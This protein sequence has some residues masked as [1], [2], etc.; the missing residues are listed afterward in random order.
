M[1]TLVAK[2]IRL[3]LPAFAG[4]LALVV[5]PMWAMCFLPPDIRSS[6]SGQDVMV[7][8][9]Y[10]IGILMLALSSFGREF[11]LKTLPFLLAQPVE[12]ARIWR[13]KVAVLAVF[14]SVAVAL[15]C[16]LAD[17]ILILGTKT[18]AGLPLFVIL[19]IAFTAGAICL[20]LLLRQVAAA[21]WLALLIPMALMLGLEALRI[22]DSFLFAILGLYAVAAFLLARWQFLHLQDTA[23]TGGVVAF[24]RQRQATEQSS[25]RCHRPWAALFWKEIQMQ[26]VTFFGMACLLALHLGVV[27]IRKAG[28]HSFA[29]TT[30]W[31]LEAFGMMWFVVPILAGSQSVAEE[32]KLGT[33]QAHLC[34]PISR[35]AQWDL[36]LLVV[37]AISMVSAALFFAVQHW[38]Q[39]LSFVEM[40]LYFLL[41]ALAGF[42]GSTLTSGVVQALAVGSL[43]LLGLW[44]GL[45]GGMTSSP[46]W[47]G[48]LLLYIGVPLLA[49]T[50]VWL[51]YR[52]FG[53]V[54][55]SWPL[56]RRNILALLG[57][58]AF[59]F[60]L[61]AAIY[62]RAWEYLT[63]LESTPGPARLS[64]QHPPVF[65]TGGGTAMAAILPDG[66]LW[67]DR[68]GL[69]RRYR[70]TDL[71]AK[72]VSVGGNAFVPGSNWA[73][74]AVDSR[75][76]VAIR[77]DGTLW[78][79]PKQRAFWVAARSTFTVKAAPWVQFGT[80]TDWQSVV[81]G[82][83]WVRDPEWTMLLLKRNGTLWGW[84]TN[85]YGATQKRPSLL[86]HQ[87]RQFGNDSDWATLLG[88]NGVINA[89]AWKTNGDAW[90]F[91][92][93]GSNQLSSLDNTRWRCL[94]RL[95]V[96]GFGFTG[97]G[98]TGVRDDGTLW[99]SE[100]T[101][102]K[103][104]S[105]VGPMQQVG[106]ASDW[107]GLAATFNRLVARKTNGSLW[108]WNWWSKWALMA[109][110]AFKKPP[111]RLGAR[112]DWVA[113][114]TVNNQIATLS[115]DGSL[116][117]WPARWPIPLFGDDSDVQIA[118][119]RKPVKIENIFGAQQ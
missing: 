45:I 3:L 116:W 22:I 41:F 110:K 77:A 44:V 102:H 48:I 109:P 39:R 111:V 74:V 101:Y 35:R 12:R 99:T 18:S 83:E 80:D 52:N 60:T 64:L 95:D 30:L 42:Y 73:D 37:F 91:Q 49:A 61:T 106:N 56:W 68:V 32:R 58:M 54:F 31:M 34:L 90:G 59:S 96:S 8:Y 1:K 97:L 11:G 43:T 76:T 98:F 108:E 105:V 36:K 69:F 71:D 40:S 10:Y 24:G 51:S 89:Y 14:V 107:A 82:P 118:P 103:W 26:Q 104:D 117:L 81:R 4:A 78:I 92:W 19:A 115:S 72:W 55:E 93:D 87:P 7:G 47:T 63:P 84:G 17:Y 28:A 5:L 23:W 38:V 100:S 21:F 50:V 113:I 66:R 86:D 53:S 29:R 65:H 70:H 62:N 75:E 20:A 57:M 6:S 13:I 114:G 33:M 85:Y 67:V 2:E 15:W 25:Q 27:A 16:F 46:L 9:L 119:S 94:T 88:G 79:S 112:S